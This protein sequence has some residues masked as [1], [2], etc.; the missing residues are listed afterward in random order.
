MAA[1]SGSTKNGKYWEDAMPEK[2]LSPTGR[3]GRWVMDV[4]KPMTKFGG[5]SKQL[6]RT[7]YL[8][9]LRG[10]AAIVVYWHHHQLWAHL[11]APVNDVLQNAWGYHGKYHFATMPGIRNFFTGGH[12]AVTVFFVI[13][14]YVLSTKPM[15]LI[16]AG[17]YSKLGENL[18]SALFRRWL[19]LYIPVIVTTFLYMTS[20]HMFGIWTTAKHQ[21]SYREELWFWYSEFKNFSFIFT[22]GGEP[23]FTYNFH[24]WS[25]PVE[26]KGSIVI[27]TALLAFSRCTRNARLLCEVGLIWYFMYIADAWYCAAFTAGM[28]LCDLDLLE[29][30]D[31]LPK[32]FS[33]MEP[34]KELIFYNLFIISFF[35]GGVPSMNA[36]I[37]TLR[38]SPGWYYLSFLKP[39]AVFDYKWF[40]LFWAATFIVAA[41]PRIPW[42]KAFFET[43]FNQH[44]GRISY[45]FY[46]VHGPI[47]WTLGDRLYSMVGW[48]HLDQL[49]NIPNWVDRFPLSKT[50][51]LGMEVAFLVPNLILFPLTLWVAEIVTRLVDEPSVKF[52]QWFLSKARAEAPSVKS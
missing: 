23:W 10:F 27:Y 42:L 46:L 26:F 17:D 24:V 11:T 18:G 35:L 1:L 20:W 9:G 49:Q 34:Y 8:D 29:M 40:Y 51:P 36:E 4:T 30:S 45:A 52:A 47:L 6:R 33:I 14:G 5:P 50:G 25:I 37:E 13:S 43:R 28:L 19:R 44:L 7:A 48:A 38:A 3:A 32:F 22:G 15:S 2:K 39:Q 41:T 12:Y 16:Q 21:A 31:D